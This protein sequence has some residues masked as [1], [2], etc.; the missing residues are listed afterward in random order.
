MVGKAPQPTSERRWVS[1]LSR[2]LSLGIDLQFPGTWVFEM[3]FVARMVA[4]TRLSCY[5]TCIGSGN[6]HKE[7]VEFVQLIGWWKISR[8]KE[9][10]PIQK[11]SWVLKHVPQ[12]AGS[13]F[14]TWPWQGREPEKEVQLTGIWAFWSLRKHLGPFDKRTTRWWFQI[15]SSFTPIWGRFPFWL[16]FVRWVETT[17][18]TI[19]F[20]ERKHLPWTLKGS[21]ALFFGV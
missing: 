20:D 2:F 3:F 1:C 5:F 9:Q 6:L 8:K 17:N 12:Q 10:S 4:G 19:I 18:H 15:L 16:V 7:G 13:T 14:G 11:N 21:T